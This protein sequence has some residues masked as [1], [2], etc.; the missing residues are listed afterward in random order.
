MSTILPFIV[1]LISLVLTPQEVSLVF[2][3]DA[4]QHQGQLDAPDVLMVLMDMTD[5]SM[6]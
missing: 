6:P 5:V 4:M 1:Q 3:G 2:A